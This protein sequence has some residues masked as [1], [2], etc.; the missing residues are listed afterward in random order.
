MIEGRDGQRSR[1]ERVLEPYVAGTLLGEVSER[2]GDGVLRAQAVATRTRA[3]LRRAHPRSTH[4]DVEA[5]TTE[6]VYC[7][8]AR[9]GSRHRQILAHFRP[10]TRIEPLSS[11][12]ARVAGTSVLAARAGVVGASQ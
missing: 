8:V 6:T 7:A 2:F 12:T 5:A 9:S 10:G 11:Q 4:F 1:N 3:L